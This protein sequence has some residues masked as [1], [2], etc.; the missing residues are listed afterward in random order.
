M[1][2]TELNP[3][4]WQMQWDDDNTFP[5]VEDENCN[6]TGLGWQD[7]AEFAAEVN[8]YDEVAGGEPIDPDEQWTADDISYHYAVLDPDGERLHQVGPDV[9]GAIKVTALWGLR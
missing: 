1:T 2:S 5:F 7:K 4:D 8:R 9:Q 6:I 3:S